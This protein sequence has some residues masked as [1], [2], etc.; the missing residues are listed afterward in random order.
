MKLLSLDFDGVLHNAA[1]QVAINFREGM[2]PWQMEIALK[3]QQR[4]VWAHHLASILENTDV[5]VIIHSTWRKRFSD[6]TMKQFLPP[7]VASRLLSLD[8]QIKNRETL[9]ADDYL[10]EAL[11]LIQP[12][13]LCVLDDR[14]EFFKGGRVQQW[15][16]SAAGCFVWTEPDVG[17]Q[18]LYACGQLTAWS[19]A[20]PGQFASQTPPPSSNPTPSSSS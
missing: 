12:T 15:I 16:N 14:R 13:S 19:H 11:E 18:S 5:A 17:L 9:V 3:A 10:A 20:G 2:A 1:D 6:Q 7:V 4:F 8:G